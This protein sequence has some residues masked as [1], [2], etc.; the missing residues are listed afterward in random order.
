M[1]G[2]KVAASPA[3]V[4]AVV[5]AGY[6]V[7]VHTWDHHSLTGASTHTAPLT[8]SEVRLEV[9]TTIQALVAAGAPRPTLWRPPYGDVDGQDISIAESLGLR[10]VMPW[11]QN[12][13]ITDNGDWT[14]ATAQTIVDNVTKGVV[15]WCQNPRWLDHRWPRWH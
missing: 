2:E 9:V 4:Q 7:E 13:S 11:S 15:G 3:I 14:G 1:I 6:A 12:D 8:P 10:L 5:R